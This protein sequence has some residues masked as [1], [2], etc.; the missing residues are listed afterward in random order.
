MDKCRFARKNCVCKYAVW[1]TCPIFVK[2]YNTML[3]KELIPFHYK[4]GLRVPLQYECLYSADVDSIKSVC[5][6][7]AVV[8]NASIKVINLNQAISLAISPEEITTKVLFIECNNR[9]YGDF[10]KVKNVFHSFVDRL[11]LNGVKVFIHLGLLQ[12]KNEEWTKL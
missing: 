4:K 12:L 11:T 5:A 1:R 3:I 9:P 6:D 2:A 7:F 10:D 8:K